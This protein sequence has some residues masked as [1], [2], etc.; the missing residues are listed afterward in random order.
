VPLPRTEEEQQDGKVITW[1]LYSPLFPKGART[2]MDYSQIVKVNG[3][4]IDYT[5]VCLNLYYRDG[6]GSVSSDS[7]D[8]E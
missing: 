3:R 7:D 5:S 2:A 6:E 8:E 4:A 1:E